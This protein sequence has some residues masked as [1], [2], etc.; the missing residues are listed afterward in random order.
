ME[1]LEGLLQYMGWPEFKTALFR[2]DLTTLTRTS[3]EAHLENTM[4]YV[5][6]VRRSIVEGKIDEAKSMIREFTHG[7]VE[8]D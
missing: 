1:E 7:H 3:I 8:I 5:L 6:D 4:Q 2:A